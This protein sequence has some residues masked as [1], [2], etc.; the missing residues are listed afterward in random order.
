MVKIHQKVCKETQVK[1]HCFTPF[2]S[3]LSYHCC[4]FPQTSPLFYLASFLQST[5]SY[6]CSGFTR[7]FFQLRLSNSA[8]T[9]SSVTSCTFYSVIPLFSQL[10]IVVTSHEQLEIKSEKDELSLLVKIKSQMKD[11]VKD[12]PLSRLSEEDALQFLAPS[13]VDIII[14]IYTGN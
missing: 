4:I 3:Y 6:Y 13:L 11:Y 2:F 14:N 7:T 12:I 8:T 10:K 9:V 1:H 5:R